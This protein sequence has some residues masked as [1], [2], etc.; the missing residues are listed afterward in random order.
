MPT[1]VA[2]VIVARPAAATCSFRDLVGDLRRLAEAMNEPARR[3][4]GRS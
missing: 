2:L 3:R 4:T 1:N